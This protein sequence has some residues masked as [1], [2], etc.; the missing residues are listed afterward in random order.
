MGDTMR[1]KEMTEQQGQE[2]EKVDG[3]DKEQHEADEEKDD[4]G[5]VDY[6]KSTGFAAQV[7]KKET[8]DKKIICTYQIHTRTTEVSPCV[9]GP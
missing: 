7:T 8:Q 2:V 3:N 5:E 1:V 6:K 9:V 4:G